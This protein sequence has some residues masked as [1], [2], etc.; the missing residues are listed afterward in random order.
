MPITSAGLLLYRT[1][2][3]PLEV[4]L[5]HPGGPFYAK[6]DLGVWS[7]PKG[8]F[9]AEK[10]LAAAK[11]EFKEETGYTIKGKFVELTP[12]KMKSGKRVF[13]FAIEAD[14]DADVIKSNTFS[15]EFPPGSGNKKEYPEIDR[16][17]WFTISEAKEKMLTYQL[18]F[19]AELLKKT[20]VGTP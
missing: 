19:L 6:K 11:R 20:E 18:P 4:F 12:V 14:I 1:T 2:N 17:R 3:G 7:I 9:T 16:A 15:L 8:E 10:P 5:A 13:A